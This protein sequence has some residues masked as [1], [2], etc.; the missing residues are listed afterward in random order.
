[1]GTQAKK[2]N[3]AS[4][5]NDN[6]IESLRDLGSSVPKSVG[7]DVVGQVPADILTALTGGMP[8]SGE[9]K[10]YEEVTFTKERTEQLLQPVRSE[11]TRQ[12][13]VTIEDHR[14][15]TQLDAVRA[16]LSALAQSLKNLN[17][18]VERAIVETPVDPGIYHVNFLE[19][20]RSFIK[21]L[22]EQVDDSRTW[23]TVSSK[24]QKKMAFWGLYKKHGTQ[25]GLSSERT[26]STQAG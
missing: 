16:E 15:K 21:L 9:I 4:Y 2:P 18:D 7:R 17:T 25:F 10:A 22:R 26:V 8:K 13:S 23:L 3:V 6:V 12:P 5:I 20:L 19:R 1:M 24:R 11:L 14:V